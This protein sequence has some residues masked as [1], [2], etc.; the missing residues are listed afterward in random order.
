MGIKDMYNRH[1]IERFSKHEMTKK[2]QYT[3][4][5][6][7]NQSHNKMQSRHNVYRK[8]C[9]DGGLFVKAHLLYFFTYTLRSATSIQSSGITC[10]HENAIHQHQLMQH[11]QYCY[12]SWFP[13]EVIGKLRVLSFRAT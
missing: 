12:G 10:L 2:L 1:P 9:K 11:F 5:H 4:E 3:M 6:L 13:K 7:L 8:L